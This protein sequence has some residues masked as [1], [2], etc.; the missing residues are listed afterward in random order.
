MI[1]GAE[2]FHKKQSKAGEKGL[3]NQQQ[4]RQKGS[5]L[6]SPA[7]RNEQVDGWQWQQQV[8]PARWGRVSVPGAFSSPHAVSKQLAAA[9]SSSS[10]EY[11][12]GDLECSYIVPTRCVSCQEEEESVLPISHMCSISI[13]APAF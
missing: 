11:C 9:F 7:T 3:K 13:G 2:T 6:W 5:E 12:I 4:Q 8:A 10:V 1:K